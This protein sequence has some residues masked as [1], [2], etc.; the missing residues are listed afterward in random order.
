MGIGRYVPGADESGG[1]SE[2]R[3]IGRVAAYRRERRELIERAVERHRHGGPLVDEDGLAFQCAGFWRRLSRRFFR[4]GR[5]VGREP[6]ADAA[7]QGDGAVAQ[8]DEGRR[9]L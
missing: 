8:T 2:Q 3:G 4:F 9:H 5:Q 7:F 1:L 6:I